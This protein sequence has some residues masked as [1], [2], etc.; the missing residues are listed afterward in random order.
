MAV[1]IVDEMVNVQRW[2]RE[3][4]LT[5]NLKKKQGIIFRR[6]SKGNL[7]LPTPLQDVERVE[8]VTLIGIHTTSTLSATDHVNLILSQA[9]QGLYLLSIDSN[10]LACPLMQ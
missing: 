5:L 8:R 10:L 7:K 9:N 2:S 6:P 1:G 4:R 3:N